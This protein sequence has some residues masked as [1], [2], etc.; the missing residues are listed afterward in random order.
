L[1]RMHKNE[2]LEIVDVRQD[3]EWRAGHLPGALHIPIGMVAARLGDVP[4]NGK[5]VATMCA[6]GM[7]ATI[8][9]SLLRRVGFDPLVVAQGGFDDWEER[10]WPVETGR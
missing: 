9:A 7:R 2:D 6:S 1:H 5:Q 8:A 4:S 10:G 3:A